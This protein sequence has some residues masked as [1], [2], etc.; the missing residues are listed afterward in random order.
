ML[1]QLD[2][3]DKDST[4]ALVDGSQAR[5]LK[6]D[7]KSSVKT[8]VHLQEARSSLQARDRTSAGEC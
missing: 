4:P 3:S 2:A 8:E 7:L 6:F 5:R 1:L